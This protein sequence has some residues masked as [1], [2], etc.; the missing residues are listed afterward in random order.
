VKLVAPEAEQEPAS[1]LDDVI[2]L[3]HLATFATSQACMHMH[4]HQCQCDYRIRGKWKNPACSCHRSSR[5]CSIQ[6]VEED[7]I[8]LWKPMEF[9]IQSHHLTDISMEKPHHQSIACITME[10]RGQQHAREAV[11]STASSA[12]ST[13]QTMSSSRRRTWNS[14]ERIG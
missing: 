9:P 13:T 12:T 2:L 5:N 6:D 8:S 11:E 1:S 3:L 10:W 7:E 4:T 14:S